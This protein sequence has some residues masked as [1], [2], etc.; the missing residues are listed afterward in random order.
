[1]SQHK[2]DNIHL[3]WKQLHRKISMKPKATLSRILY[4]LTN[5][6][7]TQPGKKRKDKKEI[8]KFSF[9]PLYLHGRPTLAM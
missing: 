4:K 8:G 9:T 3:S 5:L 6:Y 1:M 7:P 2:E